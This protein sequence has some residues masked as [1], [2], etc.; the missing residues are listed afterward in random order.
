MKFSHLPVGQRFE[1]EG[2]CYTKVGPVTARDERSGRARMIA[3]FAEVAPLAAGA[4]ASSPPPVHQLD[5]G[6]VRAAFEAYHAAVVR[7]LLAADPEEA[8]TR[9]AAARIEFL[10]TLGLQ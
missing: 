5:A 9:L 6:R 4:G 2:V 1:F 10:A 7:V 8:R 3:R